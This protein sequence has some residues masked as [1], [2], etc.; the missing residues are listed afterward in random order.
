MSM[1]FCRGC[2]KEIHETAQRIGAEFETVACIHVQF[3][4]DTIAN[5]HVFASEFAA[6][7]ETDSIVFRFDVAFFNQHI[8]TIN[9]I[10]T[11]A[12]GSK[13]PRVYGQ[14]TND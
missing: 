9:N 4:N 3:I 5:H 11:I 12:V 8:V 7:F 1:V 2:A 13:C 6:A 10:N 14:L